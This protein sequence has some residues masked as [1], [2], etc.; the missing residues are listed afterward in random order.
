MAGTGLQIREIS[1]A[2]RLAL[3][4]CAVARKWGLIRP[5]LASKLEKYKNH[6]KDWNEDDDKDKAEDKDPWFPSKKTKRY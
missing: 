4:E 5:E 2:G 6:D 3:E 1:Y